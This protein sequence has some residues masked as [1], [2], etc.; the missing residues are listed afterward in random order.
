MPDGMES[1]L[2][3]VARSARLLLA[4]GSPYLPAAQ[5]AHPLSYDPYLPAMTIFG[6]PD[7]L[8]LPAAVDNPRLWFAV[9]AGIALWLAA[10]RA[11]RC[12]AIRITAFALASPVLAFGI[13]VGGTDVPVLALLCLA[14]A[15]VGTG[16]ADDGLTGEPGHLDVEDEDRLLLHL[17]G[18]VA[19][20]SMSNAHP[21]LL[22]CGHMQ[23][24]RRMFQGACHFVGPD[25]PTASC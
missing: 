13:A 16:N 18:E 4:H 15:L 3:V 21:E 10:R 12:S 20:Q 22:L 14:S 9:T 11:V 24:A 5:L 6:L 25:L 17:I 19:A 7:A 23:W 2:W 1:A 8:G